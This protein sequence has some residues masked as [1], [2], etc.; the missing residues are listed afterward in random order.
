MRTVGSISCIHVRDVMVDIMDGERVSLEY[1]RVRNLGLLTSLSQPTTTLS[2][3]CI[4]VTVCYSG[5]SSDVVAFC[6]TLAPDLVMPHLLCEGVI[7][8]W[9]VLS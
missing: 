1:C 5:V 7:L 8:L 9:T 2:Y 3:V 4:C 6:G